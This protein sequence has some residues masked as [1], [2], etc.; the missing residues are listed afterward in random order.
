MSENRQKF[1]LET[2]AEIPLQGTPALRDEGE[3][4]IWARLAAKGRK[5]CLLWEADM[6]L[7]DRAGHGT[8]GRIVAQIARTR[9][10]T[11]SAIRNKYDRWRKEGWTALVN[12]ARY[13][14]GGCVP[15]AAIEYYRGLCHGHQR[16]KTTA[17]QAY[18]LLL[19]RWKA[20]RKEGGLPGSDH[21][22]PGY[23]TAPAP[24]RATGLPPGWSKEQWLRRAPDQYERSLT[25]I[26]PKNYSQFLP[27]IHTTRVGILPG[28][29]VYFDDEQQ[30]VYVNFLEGKQSLMRPL[31]FHAL[32]CSS[33]CNLFRNFKPQLVLDN[34]SRRALNQEDFYWFTLAF[35]GKAGYRSDTGTMLVGEL[36]TAAWGAPFR[37]A[38]TKLTEGKVTFDAS[39]RFGDPAFRG[40]LFE[41]KS[42][43]NF[44]YK[45]PIES[46]FNLIRNY[47]ALLPGPTGRNRDNAPE[48]SAGLARYNAWCLDLVRNLPEERA[49]LVRLPCL[50]WHQYTQLAHHIIE[51]INRRTDHQLEGWA[52]S[53]YSIPVITVAD[54]EIR[55]TPDVMARST[56]EQ[57]AAFQALHAMGHGRQAAMSPHEVWER[58]DRAPFRFPR[59]WWAPALMGVKYARTVRVTPKLE[60]V[61]KDQEIDSDALIYLAE[62][63]D[64]RGHKMLLT[65]EKSYLAWLNPYDIDSLQIGD[66]TAGHEGEWLGTAPLMP[67]MAKLETE[68]IHR[69]I[70]RL[71]QATA[72]ERLAIERQSQTA[73]A[74]RT[75]AF[76]WNQRLENNKALT[77]EEHAN[78]AR[79]TDLTEALTAPAPAPRAPKNKPIL[80]DIFG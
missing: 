61:I 7:I 5:D 79:T 69:Q 70:G 34:G 25:G 15:H 3:S 49:L 46:I 55:L 37:D 52:K 53:G 2:A 23:Q 22:I 19:A 18:R 10:L 32:D 4:L 51:A 45:S 68:N 47:F 16:T 26:G 30:D 33:G 24:L 38:L 35:L 74:E 44:R 77:P 71:T 39:G 50:E 72:A 29:I 12:R 28:Q 64:Q 58:T 21:A 63:T 27:G 67:R 11:E 20:W 17:T 40:S 59:P 66:A 9:D 65:R 36:G 78:E 6:L 75:A 41:G 8:R 73:L 80:P 13:R 42:T 54:T 1:S 14:P 48:E 62:I 76:R 60:I 57:L 31:A 43:G 56:P